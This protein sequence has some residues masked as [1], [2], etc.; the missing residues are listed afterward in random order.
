[1]GQI[2]EFLILISDSD[3]LL[4]LYDFR[5]PLTK[6]VLN[7]LQRFLSQKEL[8]SDNDVLTQ[9]YILM[10]ICL[11]FNQADYLFLYVNLS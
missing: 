4:T 8:S 9:S 5:L 11:P 1:M 7:V 10:T 3:L 6:Y 2:N